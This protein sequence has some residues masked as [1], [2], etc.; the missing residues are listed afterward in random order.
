MT[1]RRKEVVK[2]R[3]K[4]GMLMI[5]LL[6]GLALIMGSMVSSMAQAQPK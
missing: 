2:M 3:F 4:K 6:S 5:V 1:K